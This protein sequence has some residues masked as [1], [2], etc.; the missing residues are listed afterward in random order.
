[1]IVID[2]Y[3][4][5]LIAQFKLGQIFSVRLTWIEFCII[6]SPLVCLGWGWSSVREGLSSMH[7]A[8]SLIHSTTRNQAWWCTLALPALRRSRQ[9][10]QELGHAHVASWRLCW[11]TLSFSQCP[12]PNPSPKN[13]SD[14][15]WLSGT[16]HEFLK[17]KSDTLYSCW[18]LLSSQYLHLYSRI[19]IFYS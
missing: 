12:T 11:A 2:Y 3:P 4:T 19:W 16:Y 5:I 10:V 1:M 15:S 18:T 8:L 17:N 7:K 9:E 6:H 13:Q 14:G